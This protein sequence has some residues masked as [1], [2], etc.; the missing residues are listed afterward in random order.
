MMIGTAI[1]ARLIFKEL[2][3]FKQWLT[4]AATCLCLVAL[5]LVQAW[6]S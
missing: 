4:I 6:N 2:L 3:S 5:G 1:S